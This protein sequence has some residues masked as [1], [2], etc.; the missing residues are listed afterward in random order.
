MG[1]NC[2]IHYCEGCGEWELELQ[3]VPHEDDKIYQCIAS[4]PDYD[5]ALE[6]LRG[7]AKE[8]EIQL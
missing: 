3:I 7:Y 1:F 6:K 8:V 2:D 4:D 5:V